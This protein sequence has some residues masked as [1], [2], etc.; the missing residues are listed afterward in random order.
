V[1]KKERIEILESEFGVKIGERVRFTRGGTKSYYGIVIDLVP[2]NEYPYKYYGYGD[3]YVPDSRLH[4]SVW[5][6]DNTV[7]IHVLAGK[8]QLK[9]YYNTPYVYKT[10]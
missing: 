3:E 4:A 7:A 2:K 9:H 5:S 10:R 6:E 8:K 1:D